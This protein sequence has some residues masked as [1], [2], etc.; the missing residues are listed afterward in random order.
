MTVRPA[1]PGDFAAVT[2]LLEQLG[3]GPVSHND[4][5]TAKQVYTDQ[6]DDPLTAHLVATDSQGRVIGVCALHFRMRLNHVTPQAWIPDLFVQRSAR[7][8]GT[9]R[10][11]LGEAERLARER[12]CW[13][14]TL[15]S[16]EERS[17]A[18]LLYSAFGMTN[19][20]KFFRKPL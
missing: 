9:A 17:E 10:A 16:G 4:Y 19:A 18:H 13:E 5:A 14:L 2:D 11:L 1:Q 7:G 20:G 15:E 8:R 12:Q 6:L 3:R